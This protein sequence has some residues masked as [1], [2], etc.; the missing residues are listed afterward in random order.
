MIR[1]FEYYHGVALRDIVVCCRPK[2]ASI[3]LADE[4]GRLNSYILDDEL[5]L[6]IKHSSG[7]VPPWQF[8]FSADALKE[9]NGLKAEARSVWLAFVCG[10]DGVVF[11][12]ESDFFEVNSGIDSAYI[13][14]DRDK[15]TM[16][17]INGSSGPL[18]KAIKRGA[19][20]LIADL[21]LGSSK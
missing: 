7:R 5:G 19:Q 12:P 10:E 14:I 18:R 4:R 20:P 15:R 2:G 6:H 16:Y 1:E 13:R 21:A 17:R 8:V 3:R 9:V 11:L